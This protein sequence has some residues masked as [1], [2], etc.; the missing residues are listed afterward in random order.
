MAADPA[1]ADLAVAG[2]AADIAADLAV[3]VAAVIVL[4]P[5]RRGAALVIGNRRLPDADRIEALAL[6]APYGCWARHCCW[7]CWWCFCLPDGRASFW[8]FMQEG[9]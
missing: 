2:L 3:W 6:G 9:A 7:G 1:A 8:F 5:N 4:R